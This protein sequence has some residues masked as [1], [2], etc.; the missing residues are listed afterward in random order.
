MTTRI[1]GLLMLLIGGVVLWGVDVVWVKGIAGMIFIAGFLVFGLD[2]MRRS[3]RKSI[4]KSRS[5]QDTYV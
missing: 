3:L 5:D 1:V 2:L 4:E